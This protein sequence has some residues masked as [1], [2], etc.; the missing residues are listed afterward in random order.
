MD[1]VDRETRSGVMRAVRSKGNRSTERRLRA[2]LA[3]A[4]VR[5]WR[6]N[7]EELAGRPDFVFDDAKLAVFVDGCFWH[8]CPRCY[9]RPS[10]NQKYWDAKVQ[11][12]MARDR[13]MRKQLRREGW[14]VLRLWEH[15]I[16]KELSGCVRRIAERIHAD[17]Q[18]RP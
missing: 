12:N 7:A 1:T 4:G 17:G 5:G 3:R 13:R 11:R 8:G 14:Q 18:E 15:Q 10:S 9:R 2:A 16:A 6:I